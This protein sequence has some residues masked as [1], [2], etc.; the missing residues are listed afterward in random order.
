MAALVRPEA[1][2]LTELAKATMQTKRGA[3]LG[4]AMTCRST[5]KAIIAVAVAKAGPEIV[6]QSNCMPVLV[7]CQDF[8]RLKAFGSVE[9]KSRSLTVVSHSGG[10][11]IGIVK[12]PFSRN[13]QLS[14]LSTQIPCYI[15]KNRV[16]RALVR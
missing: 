5:K 14:R 3:G 4:T 2:P 16:P 1:R 7:A 13:A 10:L 6:R 15:G 8:G 12:I 11:S 9:N